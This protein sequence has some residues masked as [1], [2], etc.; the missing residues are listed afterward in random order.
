MNTLLTIKRF[1]DELCY[2]DKKNKKCAVCDVGN[3]FYSVQYGLYEN[4]FDL[5]F[6]IR[7]HYGLF[8]YSQK[9]IVSGQCIS[10]MLNHKFCYVWKDWYSGEKHKLSIDEAIACK[11]KQEIEQ[12]QRQNCHVKLSY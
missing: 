3:E 9:L 10:L 2:C 8:A 4:T 11:E 6:L 5:D 7:I 1:W 12:I